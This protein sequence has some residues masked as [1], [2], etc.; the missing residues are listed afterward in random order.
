MCNDPPKHLCPEMTLRAQL[1]P[2]QSSQVPF[3]IMLLEDLDCLHTASLTVSLQHIA[4]SQSYSSLVAV[5]PNEHVLVVS[6]LTPPPS[7]P[8][9]SQLP[10]ASGSPSETSRALSFFLYSWPLA[11]TP[12]PQTSH[13][14][15]L[16][17]VILRN[18][19]MF[20]LD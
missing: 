9:F 16:L 18:L 19:D 8:C 12:P 17:S 7:A 20:F 10:N 1:Y 14:A 15:F 6:Y 5:E 3:T 2:S 13:L 11:W 4:S